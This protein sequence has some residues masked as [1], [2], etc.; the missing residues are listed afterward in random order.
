M[1]GGLHADRVRGGV[2]ARGILLAEANPVNQGVAG[3]LLRS[4][5]LTID[6]ADNGGPAIAVAC[7]TPDDAV[8]MAMQMPV[9]D[10]LSASRAIRDRLGHG[11]PVIAMTANAFEEDRDACRKARYGRSPGQTRG[12]RASVPNLAALAATRGRWRIRVGSPHQRT[13]R[14]PSKCAARRA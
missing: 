6:T 4:V 5:G 8:L 9:R 7:A 11:L 2:A 1:A 12:P 14:R 3:E 10:G 13:W